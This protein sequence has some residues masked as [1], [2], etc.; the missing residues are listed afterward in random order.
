MTRTARDA[1][2]NP[3]PGDAFQYANGDREVVAEVRHGKV[4]YTTRPGSE[5][6]MTLDEWADTAG[7]FGTWIP[8]DPD[9]CA[10]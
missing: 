1:R 10:P 3:I 5:R 7:Y 9:A 2:H 8:V 6:S 4:F